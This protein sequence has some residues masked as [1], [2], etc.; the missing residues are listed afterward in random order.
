MYVLMAG[1][2]LLQD[3]IQYMSRF[4]LPQATLD[5]PHYHNAIFFHFVDMMVIGLLITLAGQVE[6]LRFQRL[7]SSCMLLVQ[8]FY[9]VLD[10]RTSDTSFGNSLYK[11]PESMLPVVVGFVFILIFLAQAVSSFRYRPETNCGKPA[12]AA[13]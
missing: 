9:L 6:S 12:D 8:S 1:S 2:V 5:S 10:I 3:V 13:V 7:F 11:G 4:G